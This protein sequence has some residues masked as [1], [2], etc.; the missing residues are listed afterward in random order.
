MS[1]PRRD[2]DDWKSQHSEILE[3]YAGPEDLM[4]VGSRGFLVTTLPGKEEFAVDDAIDLLRQAS[5]KLY[6]GIKKPKNKKIDNNCGYVKIDFMDPKTVIILPTPEGENDEEPTEEDTKAKQEGQE[7][8]KG[9]EPMET[10]ESN[11]SEVV[12]DIQTN[13]TSET[14]IA[15]ETEDNKIFAETS[16]GTAATGADENKTTDNQESNESDE[17]KN[18]EEVKIKNV[19]TDESTKEKEDKKIQKAEIEAKNKEEEDRKIKEEDIPFMRSVHKFKAFR[20][21][22]RNVMFIKSN[23]P[24]PMEI[25]EA[26]M[27]IL[28]EHRKVKGDAVNQLLPVLGVCDFNNLQLEIMTRRVLGPIF[29]PVEEPKSFGILLLDKLSEPGSETLTEIVR[30]TIWSINPLAWM[31]SPLTEPDAL[32]RLELIGSKLVL[33]CLRKCMRYRHFSPTLL[34]DFGEGEPEDDDG[35]WITAQQRRQQEE[36]RTAREKLKEVERQKEEERRVLREKRKAEAEA[37]KKVKSKEPEKKKQKE[38]KSDEKKLDDKSSKESS[39]AKAEKHSATDEEGKETSPP[40]KKAKFESGDEQADDD[41]AETKNE[42]DKPTDTEVADESMASD[43]L[44]KQEEVTE[45]NEENAEKK[46]EE[47]VQEEKEEGDKKA[48]PKGKRGGK[49]ARGGRQRKK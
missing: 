33:S 36:W 21:E 26:A 23:V 40:L 5:I 25:A 37:R 27:E 43:E 22:I 35:T 24:D 4:E 46:E 48:K 29:N 7:E 39:E 10:N 44:T 12:D 19:V 30:N 41:K 31:S 1:G 14:K 8:I 47:E 11:P 49:S 3:I 28:L 9:K 17:N 6:G 16:E 32:I 2:H 13:E 45:V 38:R 20:T 15:S 34:V 18:T 42:E